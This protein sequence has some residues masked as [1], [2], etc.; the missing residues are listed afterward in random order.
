MSVGSYVQQLPVPIFARDVRASSRL[1]GAGSQ[2]VLFVDPDL[3]VRSVLNVALAREGFEL[4]AVGTAEE[5][6]RALGPGRLLPAAVIIEAD[7]GP[8]DGFS[9][10][11]KLRTDPR[12]SHLPVLLLSRLLDRNRRELASRAGADDLLPKPV[13]ARDIVSLVR[14]NDAPRRVAGAFALNTQRLPVP[15]LLRSLLTGMRSGRIVFFGGRGLLRFRQGKVFDARLDE[16]RGSEAL[17]RILFLAHGDYEVALGPCTGAANVEFGLRELLGHLFPMLADWE[18]LV[19]RSIPL[20]AELM[21]DFHQLGR[22]LSNLPD[23]VNAIVRLFDGRRTVRDALIDSRMTESLALEVVTRLY[24]MGVLVAPQAGPER[25]QSQAGGVLEAHERMLSLFGDEPP[26]LEVSAEPTPVGDWHDPLES[27]VEEALLDAR[28][29]APEM[30]LA[31]DESL[32]RQLEALDTPILYDVPSSSR[33]AQASGGEVS[34]FARGDA[35]PGLESFESVVGR[36]VEEELARLARESEGTQL[37]QIPELVPVSPEPTVYA[38]A[39]ELVSQVAPAPEAPSVRPP[40]AAAVH[41][42]PP[43]ARRVGTTLALCAAVLAV[44]VGAGWVAWRLALRDQPTRDWILGPG[45]LL[46]SIET[47]PPSAPTLPSEA[48]KPA[49]PLV[50]AAE[51]EPVESPRGPSSSPT[52]SGQ[53]T[54]S[55]EPAAAV[56][57]SPAPEAVPLEVAADPGVRPAGPTA[58]AGDLEEELSRAL[59]FYER[60]YIK[61]AALLLSGIVVR[62]PDDPTAWAYLG[63]TEYDARRPAAA[64]AAARKAL[65]LDPSNERA[66]MLLA[67][68]HLAA[69]RHAEARATLELYL[70]QHPK[71]A[72]A[73]EARRLLENVAAEGP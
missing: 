40:R 73:P 71:G 32:E 69:Q 4:Q 67:T 26:Q 61:K 58:E 70:E 72:F 51:L 62:H 65:S 63:L 31:L 43:L 50:A 41:P 66:I 6:I 1:A 30:P 44:S 11:G 59:R 53:G 8:T 14:L 28:V 64:E 16:L 13:F 52:S 49:V 55:P 42:T 45:A 57:P 5:A 23:G 3:S 54:V 46:S 39:P 37:P 60:G 20:E 48:P 34:A 10:C 38:P 56:V 35:D 22:A 12:T 21:V 17:T 19:A 27:A 47:P 68:L 18:A 24:S 33:S 9:L 15:H 2:W 7:L 29:I 25:V 36:A